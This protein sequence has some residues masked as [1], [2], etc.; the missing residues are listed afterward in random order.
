VRIRRL[1]ESGFKQLHMLLGMCLLDVGLRNLLHHEVCVD[2][3]FLD[4]LAMGDTPG[5]LDGQNTNRWLSIDERVDTSGRVR[6]SQGVCRLWKD[7]VSG[8][9]GIGGRLEVECDVPGQWACGR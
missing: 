3:D 4:E 6:Q 2:L 9:H 8:S 7:S 5:A 1:C